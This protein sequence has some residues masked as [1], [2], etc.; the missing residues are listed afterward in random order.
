MCENLVC[1]ATTIGQLQHSEYLKPTFL[2]TLKWVIRPV[3][4]ERVTSFSQD[5]FLQISRY[6]NRAVRHS[7]RKVKCSLPSNP[8][9]C[10]CNSSAVLC[11]SF[12]DVLVCL[13]SGWHT[14]TCSPSSLV[15][16]S[17]LHILSITLL[18]SCHCLI[19]S[20]SSSSQHIPKLQVSC[21][22][23]FGVFTQYRLFV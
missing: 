15:H 2:D 18:Q 7:S 5:L 20:C 9:M 23:P 14:S 8:L 13:F 11:Y 21:C 6:S 10:Q 16:Y 22:V 19:C 4:P 3:F 17:R 12:H 1:V